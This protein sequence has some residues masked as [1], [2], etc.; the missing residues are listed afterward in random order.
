MP[1]VTGLTSARMLNIEANSVVSGAIVGNDLIL[2]KFNAATI[3]AGN[4]RGPQ[5]DIGPM[6]EVSLAELVAALG[7]FTEYVASFT[8]TLTGMAIGTGGSAS[9]TAGYL[10]IGGS[11]V[12][13][14]GILCSWG[15]VVFGTSTPTYP[16]GP[17]ILLPAGFNF[18]NPSALRS[19]KGGIYFNDVNLS[20][21]NRIGIPFMVNSNAMAPLRINDG[22]NSVSSLTTSTPFIWQVGDSI[23]WDYQTPVIR[24]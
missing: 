11:N 22:G 18:V 16:T 5:G 24:V 7:D 2:T 1:T 8:P 21:N 10:Y 17:T 23:T 12:G 13:D 3:N 14:R 20:S 19:L 15:A 9:N 4:V 6:G